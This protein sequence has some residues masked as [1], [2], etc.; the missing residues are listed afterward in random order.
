MFFHDIELDWILKLQSSLRSSSLDQFFLG[1]NYVD[2]FPFVFLVVL[3]SWFYYRKQMGA[4]LL[5]LF[6]LS[7]LANIFLKAL[8]HLPRP[9]QLDPTVGVLQFSSYGFPSGAA[10]SAA[11]I[12][13]VVWQ[14]TVKRRY[15]LI[16]LLFA[17]FLCF[18]R[19]YLGV[20]FISD[21]LGGIFVGCVLLAI[22]YFIF[23]Q[24][25]KT[26]RSLYLFVPFL[27]VGYGKF[28][29]HIGIAVGVALGLYLD[30]FLTQEQESLFVKTSE[31]FLA[32]V[33]V[34]LCLFCHSFWPKGTLLFGAAGGFWMSF[35]SVYLVQKWRELLRAK[36]A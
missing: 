28:H 11:I 4:R 16:A 8:F 2:T 15:R 27:L 36:A 26:G 13:G 22:Q 3:T 29:M 34:S 32:Y 19:V 21:I 35:L 7:S 31:F 18:S 1:W 33:G 20:H 23:P 17:L 5:Y 12:V 6:I 14:E 10:Q 30:R 25:E 9:C 24:V